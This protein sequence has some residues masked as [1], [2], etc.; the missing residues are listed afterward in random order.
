[1]VGQPVPPRACS[2]CEFLDNAD[3]LGAPN[4]GAAAGKGA[5]EGIEN[6]VVRNPATGN[7]ITDIDLISGG[8]LWEKKSAGWADNIQKWVAKSIYKKFADYVEARKYLCGYEN[9]PIGFLFDE[10]PFDP[11]LATAIENAIEALRKAN[12]NI[13][14]LLKW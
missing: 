13:T 3:N 2:E 9:A 8:I 11:A 14:I 10:K 1:M 6:H 7:A 5:L 4:A 12:P